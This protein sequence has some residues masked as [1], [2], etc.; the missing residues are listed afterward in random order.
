MNLLA[1]SAPGFT[2]AIA[3][4]DSDKATG[5]A[6]MTGTMRDNYERYAQY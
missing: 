1:C 2:F 3:H 4:D 6:W 5:L